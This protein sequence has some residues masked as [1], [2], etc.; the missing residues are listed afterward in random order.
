[1]SES[2]ICVHLRKTLV[3]LFGSARRF[4]YEMGKGL[5]DIFIILVYEVYVGDETLA[6]IQYINQ[7]RDCVGNV[8]AVHAC[9]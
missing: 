5:Y 2:V 1:M 9:I 8:E 7:P 4:C 6:G 3:S